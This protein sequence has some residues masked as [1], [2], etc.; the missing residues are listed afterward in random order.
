MKGNPTITELLWLDGY[1]IQTK[2]GKMLV[3][4]RHLFLS[5]KYIRAAYSGYVFSQARKLNARG[6][7]YGNGRNKRYA[8]HSRHLFRLLY[9]GKELLETG[10]LT[11]RVTKEMRDELFSLENLTV[12]QLIDRFDA[13][14][15]ELDN[16]KSILPDQPDFENI[17][18]MMLRIRK[19]N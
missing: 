1:R 13:E 4:N 16:I 6:D 8:K 3:D 17:N 9:Q 11:V 18:R 10:K 19:G 7:S 5:T 15:K 14:I 2:H 12:N